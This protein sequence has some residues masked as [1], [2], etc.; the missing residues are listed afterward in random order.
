MCINMTWP[1]SLKVFTPCF[2]CFCFDRD[3]TDTWGRV[4]GFPPMLSSEGFEMVLK[5]G[6]LKHS[7]QVS[8]G[9]SPAL[10]RLESIFISL[11]GIWA[12][13]SSLLASLT[14]SE[15][16]AC[17]HTHYR[18]LHGRALACLGSNS[19]AISATWRN[20]KAASHLAHTSCFAHQGI[21]VLSSI[22]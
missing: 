4:C 12:S 20:S 11:L 17:A 1:Y 22:N 16:A 8:Q 2:M 10:I 15:V 14:L 3:L 7:C 21:W 19:C 9:C 5:S 13:L 6:I 18:H